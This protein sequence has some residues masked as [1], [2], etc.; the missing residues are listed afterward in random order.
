M[1]NPYVVVDHILK[2]ENQGIAGTY[3]ISFTE[4]DSGDRDA[5]GQWVK[6]TLS[7]NEINDA[8]KLP[9]DTDNESN[10]YETIN[11]ERKIKSLKEVAFTGSYDS[12]VDAP[13][14]PNVNGERPTQFN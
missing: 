1:A 13:E 8:P 2:D 10:S 9:E 14:I 7:Y 11:D 6:D 4:L 12:L 5:I 3:N